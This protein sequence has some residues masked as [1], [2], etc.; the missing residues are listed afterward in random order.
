[1]TR[2][3][4]AVALVLL[5]FAVPAHGAPAAKTAAAVAA[6]AAPPPQNVSLQ[7]NGVGALSAPLQ[8]VLLLTLLSF[9]PAIA[10]DR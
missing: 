9:L 1:M 4:A 6:T 2:L 8:I 3:L 5:V 7:I 10:R